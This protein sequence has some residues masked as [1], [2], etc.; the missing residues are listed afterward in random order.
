MKP[1]NEK[2]LN[3]H[4]IFVEL[5]E[6]RWQSL[7]FRERRIMEKLIWPDICLL[8]ARAYSGTSYNRI[9]FKQKGK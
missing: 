5:S 8:G 6:Q 3:M 9:A 7:P 1:K 2:G 4:I